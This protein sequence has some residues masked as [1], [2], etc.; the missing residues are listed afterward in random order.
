MVPRTVG[1]CL[2]PRGSHADQP[3]ESS[4]LPPPEQGES[5]RTPEDAPP[6]RSACGDVT[7][8]TTVQ[9][10]VTSPDGSGPFESAFLRQPEIFWVR[11][12]TGAS[13]QAWERHWAMGDA[14][15]HD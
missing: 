8:R 6:G 13:P 1:R 2:V 15:Q 3:R 9:V 7:V 12:S 11:V 5:G 4:M 10:P 14:S